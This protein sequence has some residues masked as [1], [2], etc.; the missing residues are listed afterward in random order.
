MRNLYLGMKFS[1]SYFSIFP[2]SFSKNDNLSN[3]NI[4][5]S[6]LFFFPFVGLFLGVITV[7]I[8]LL[9]AHFGWYGAIISAVLYMMMYGFIHTEAIIDVIDAIYAKHSGKDAYRVIKESTIG[10][11]GVLYAV[12]FM[13]IKIAGIVYLLIHSLFGEFISIL[14]LSRLSLLMLID[15]LEFKSSFVSQLKE[16]LDW[17]FLIPS[18]LLSLLIGSFLTP[19]FLIIMVFGFVL[20]LGVAIVFS[21]KIGFT[22]GDVLGATLEILELILF[23]VIS[24]F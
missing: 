21:K 2:I 20:A 15:T 23:M 6:M 9:L 17:K 3:P 14:I 8:Y 24:L 7:G 19:F 1:L 12:G 16:S 10:A 18:F 22:N 13:I 5:G 4:L 11:M